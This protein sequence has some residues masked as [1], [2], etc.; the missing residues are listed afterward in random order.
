MFIAALKE[1]VV[2]YVIFAG[3]HEQYP[4]WFREEVLDGILV[5]EN[6]YTRYIPRP[7]RSVDYYDKTLVEN[8]T[9]FLRK[10]TLE[11]HCVSY[12]IFEEL[13]IPLESNPRTNSGMAA[14]REDTIEV[15]ECHGGVPMSYPGWFYDYFSDGIVIQGTDQTIL[16]YGEER[17]IT[18]EG[19]CYFLRNRMG[20]IA[21][22]DHETFSKYFVKE[23]VWRL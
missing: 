18:V 20:Q 9:V 10:P 1:G 17:E 8:D 2:D 6:R 23:G 3:D 21:H 14:F 12:D 15:V 13:Y 7:E 19:H 4:R 16:F 11:V 22:M 5:D